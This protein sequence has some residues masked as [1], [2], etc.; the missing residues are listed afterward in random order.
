MISDPETSVEINAYIDGSV[1]E[2][3][4]NEGV[5]IESHGTLIQ[6]VIGVGGEKIGELY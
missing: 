4:K 3:I 6:G 2:V 1:V 5:V